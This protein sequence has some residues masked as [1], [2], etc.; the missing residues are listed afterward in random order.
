MQEPLFVG[1][2]RDRLRDG[3][4][5][6]ADEKAYLVALDQLSSFLHPGADI[7]GRILDEQLDG[8]FKDAAVG[9]Y[10]LDGQ[11]DAYY[12]ILRVRG[13]D[14]SQGINHADPDRGLGARRDDGGGSGGVTA[15]SCCAFEDGATIEPAPVIMGHGCSSQ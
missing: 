12:F 2:L 1:D 11:L 8:T 10:L 4:V 13:I 9:V 3:R 5:H 14:A 15:K 7:V 6:I